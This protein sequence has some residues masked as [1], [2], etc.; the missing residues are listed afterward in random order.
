MKQRHSF[1]NL[2]YHMVFRTKHREHLIV[3]PEAERALFGFLQTKAHH[4]DAYILE[5]GGWREHVHLL[6]RTRPTMALSEVYGQLKGFSSRCWHRK[7]PEMPFGWAD[8]VWAM[9]VDPS[10]C[11]GL[12]LYIRSQHAHHEAATAIQVWEPDD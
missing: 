2:L 12:I 5:I 11:E 8:G 10:N 1:T 4:L 6:I 7:F 3:T 9:T